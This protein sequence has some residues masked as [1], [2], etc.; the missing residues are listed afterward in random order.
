MGSK[1]RKTSPAVT[2][3]PRRLVTLVAP[4]GDASEVAATGDF[5]GWSKEGMRLRRRPDG[6]WAVTLQLSPGEYE[7]RLIVDGRWQNNPGAER[8]AANPFGSQNDVLVV[9]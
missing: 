5:T 9:A 8:H 4:V 6:A 3:S 2:S 7:Y 1:S